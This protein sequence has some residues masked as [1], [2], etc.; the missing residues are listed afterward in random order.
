MLALTSSSS[1]MS[2]CRLCRHT[3]EGVNS[4]VT[5]AIKKMMISTKQQGKN[6]TLFVVGEKGRSQLSRIHADVSRRKHSCK[7]VGTVTEAGVWTAVESTWRLLTSSTTK[8]G[9][10]SCPQNA[11]LVDTTTVTPPAFLL[12]NGCFSVRP[13]A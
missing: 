9:K 12:S 2:R 8:G 10:L 1:L 5:R 13:C 3:A 11:Y 7:G 4:F 6:T